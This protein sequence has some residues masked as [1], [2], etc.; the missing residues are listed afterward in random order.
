[1]CLRNGFQQQV[2]ERKQKRRTLPS[3]RSSKRVSEAGCSPYLCDP[4]SRVRF[5][6]QSGDLGTWGCRHVPGQNN[7]SIWVNPVP[8]RNR[9]KGVP[10]RRKCSCVQRKAVERQD[11]SK[12]WWSTVPSFV[13]AAAAKTASLVAIA[14][15]AIASDVT[16]LTA[17]IALLTTARFFTWALGTITKLQR[18]QD[19]EGWVVR[20][21]RVHV[22]CGLLGGNCNKLWPLVVP[23]NPWR[24]DL[25]HRLVVP[26]S[27]KIQASARNR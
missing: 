1:M 7:C 8:L 24:C 26:A 15:G 22:Q 2:R 19:N 17:S 14:I 3:H 12:L 23:G 20:I 27:V 9:E 5:Q 13:V 6:R 21:S 16:D 18:R 4:E 11:I 10:R 25:P